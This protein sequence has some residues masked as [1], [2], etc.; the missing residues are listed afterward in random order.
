MASRLLWLAPLAL[1]SFTGCRD[2]TRAVGEH[3]R[4]EYTL[5][6]T[7]EVPQGDL[8]DARLVTGHEQTLELQLTDRGRRDIGSPS[9]LQHRISPALHAEISTD[10]NGSGDASVKLTVDEPGPYTVQ[11]LLHGEVMDAI[12]L[13]FA[14]PAGFEVLVRVRPPWG[15][16]FHEVTSGGTLEVEQGSQITLQP[17]PVDASHRRLAGALHT[18][19][20]IAPDWAVTP[21]VGVLDVD[22]WGVWAVRGALDFYLIEPGALT[23]TFRDTVNDVATTQAFEVGPVEH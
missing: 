6:T 4:V 1:L 5:V 15:E 12:D 16:T 11:S 7:Y 20:D 23:F 14:R 8:R 22:E 19:V 21:G 10:V 18:R 3:G 9:R 13:Q 17:I 2:T